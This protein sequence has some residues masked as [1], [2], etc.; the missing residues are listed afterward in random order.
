MITNR[1]GTL[2][3]TRISNYKVNWTSI[4]RVV[5][6]RVEAS[7][8]RWVHTQWSKMRVKM[9]IFNDDFPLKFLHSKNHKFKFKKFD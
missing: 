8:L 5:A 7:L 9:Q 6:K 1:S 4:G 3:T 2:H